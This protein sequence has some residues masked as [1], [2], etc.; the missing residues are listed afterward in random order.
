MM[1]ACL[2]WQW[3]TAETETNMRLP[4]TG[5]LKYGLVVLKGQNQLCHVGSLALLVGRCAWVV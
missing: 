2:N 1:S 3:L 5:K 4:E